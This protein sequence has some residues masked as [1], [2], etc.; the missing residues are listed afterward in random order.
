M[1]DLVVWSTADLG[2]GLI[3]A[4]GPLTG[5]R[6]NGEVTVTLD[7]GTYELP[8]GTVG[9]P[10]VAGTLLLSYPVATLAPASLSTTPTAVPVR[11]L[12]GG[13]MANSDINTPIVW[14]EHEFAVP[15][16][17]V[18]TAISGAATV[19]GTFCQ[20]EQIAWW[21]ELPAS[22]TLLENDFARAGISSE[23]FAIL[24]W[25]GSA[26]NEDRAIDRKWTRR[27]NWSIT[28]VGGRCDDV[29]FRR[30]EVLRLADSVDA[31]LHRRRSVLHSGGRAGQ[32]S[33]A[34]GVVVTG[35]KM[36][37]AGPA[38]HAVEIAFQTSSSI[39]GVDE[40]TLATYVAASKMRIDT[41]GDRAIPMTTGAT[42]AIPFTEP[43]P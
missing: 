33:D 37:A 35:R 14:W 40:A 6:A 4:L 27:D 13:L 1:S 22:G 8:F 32:I 39:G 16:G 34:G 30:A 5:A 38:Y 21:D 42:Y 29:A 2:Y 15:E 43:D 11:S 25:R 18:S 7:A 31:L 20:L 23:R 41:L 17:V 19:V 36:R 26:A 10:R 3:A 24:S 12:V 9:F 28:V